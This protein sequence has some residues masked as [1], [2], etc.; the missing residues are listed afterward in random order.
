MVIAEGLRYLHS[1][2]IL[3]RNIQPNSI[4]L[5]D[6]FYPKISNFENIVTFSERKIQTKKEPTF[7]GGPFYISPEVY[8]KKKYSESSDVY[9]FS[10]T[11]Y[12]IITNEKPFNIADDNF[13][14]M[15]DIVLNKKN[16]LFYLDKFLKKIRNSWNSGHEVRENVHHFIQL[17]VN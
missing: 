14:K 15:K 5:D 1:Q 12:E 8:K 4:Q 17:L 6:S 10:I 9:A 16:V 13:E 3:H 2:S 11:I 7:V